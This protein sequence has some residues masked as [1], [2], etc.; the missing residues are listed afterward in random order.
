VPK[1]SED[2]ITVVRPPF[3]VGRAALNKGVG[4]LAGVSVPETVGVPVT[5]GVTV[6]VFVDVAVGVGVAV[7]ALATD[8]KSTTDRASGCVKRITGLMNTPIT[9]GQSS[10]PQGLR[11]EL[12][13]AKGARHPR[14]SPPCAVA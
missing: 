2:L 5:V 6:G 10:D 4:V 7:W 13:G 8:A 14:L 12:S 9:A 3:S 1:E 11:E